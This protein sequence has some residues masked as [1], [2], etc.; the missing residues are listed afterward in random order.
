VNNISIRL[1]SYGFLP[2]L[3]LAAARAQ[4]S[5]ANQP[6]E[7]TAPPSPTVLL[8][9]LAAPKAPK[10]TCSG[11]QLAISASNSTLEGILTSLRSCLGVKVDLPEGSIESRVFEDF[12]PGPARQVLE[13]LLSGTD[14]DYVIASSEANPQKIESVV[15]LLRTTET[16]SNNP[17][18]DSTLSPARRAW[19]QS[20]HN[21]RPNAVPSPGEDGAVGSEDST[22]SSASVSAPVETPTTAPSPNPS[23]DTPAPAADAPAPAADSVAAMG[24]TTAE[25]VSAASNPAVSSDKSTEERITDMQQMFQQRRMMNQSQQPNSTTQQP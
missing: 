2:L 25:P 23:T 13:S 16:A 22:D 11:D 24:T 15:L 12:G 19:L 18:Q 7:A 17:A 4:D 6:G 14:F 8:P 20:R 1:I 9:T 3:S 10:V 5:K 21:A